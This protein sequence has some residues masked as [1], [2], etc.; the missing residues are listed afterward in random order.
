MVSDSGTLIL[1]KGISGSGKSTRVYLFLEYLEHIGVSFEPFKFVNIEGKEREI[2]VYA[3]DLDMVFVGKF[4]ENGGIR[5]WQGYDSVTGR[6]HKAEGLSYFLTEMSNAGHTVVIDG[7]GTTASW[8]LRPLE[9][10]T[11]NGILN[12]LHIRYDYT[13]EQ[14]DEYCKRIVYRSG[15]EPKGDAMWRKHGTFESDYK[16]AVEEAKEVNDLGACVEVYNRSYNTPVYDLGASILKF[17]GLPELVDDFVTYCKNSNY[18]QLNSF[19][20]FEN[21]KENN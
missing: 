9:L 19:E 6:L 2:G 13:D 18:L 20:T 15:K 4:Y 1:V 5:R 17:I 7:A 12:I 10:G 21:G 8:R 16:K 14:W 3:K 11:T